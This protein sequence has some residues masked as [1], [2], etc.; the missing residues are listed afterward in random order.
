MDSACSRHMSSDTSKVTSVTPRNGGC[1]TFGDNNKCKIVGCGTIGIHPNPSIENILLVDGLKHNLLSISQLCD[2]GYKVIFDKDQYLVKTNEH[3]KILFVGTRHENV[4]T[5]YLD[6]IV[7]LKC[8]SAITNF[9]TLWHRRLAHVDV[10][11]LYKLA[12]KNLM[13]GL[14]NVK[15]EQI[16]ICKACQQGKQTRSSFKSTNIVSTT[17]PLQ[18]LPLDLFGSTRTLSLGRK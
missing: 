4:Y 16:K 13:N 5:I 7:D 9:S 8:L 10:D 3:E 1:V 18:L 2:K 14:S 15:F 12:R 17:R 6:E 11:L